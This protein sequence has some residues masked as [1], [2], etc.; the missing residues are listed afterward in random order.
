MVWRRK[1]VQYNWLDAGKANVK[2]NKQNKPQK[3]TKQKHQSNKQTKP[4][5][6]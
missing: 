2:T 1:K 6:N 4:K 3:P 5:Q